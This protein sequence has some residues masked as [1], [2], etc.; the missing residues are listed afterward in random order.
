MKELTYYHKI[1]I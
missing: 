1:L